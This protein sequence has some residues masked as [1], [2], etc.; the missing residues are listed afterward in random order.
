MKSC[1]LAKTKFADLV[2]EH[3][4]CLFLCACGTHLRWFFPVLW[5]PDHL[6]KMLSA[7]PA[8][9]A[10]EGAICGAGSGI[11]RALPSGRGPWAGRG[12]GSGG[13]RGPREAP[14][15]QVRR[16]AVVRLH[17]LLRWEVQ[18]GLEPHAF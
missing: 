5:G 3:C 18:G 10:E 7:E 11:R 14:L 1:P 16:R 6:R 4:V 17:E 13:M 8:V 15:L 12:T 2:P 9:C